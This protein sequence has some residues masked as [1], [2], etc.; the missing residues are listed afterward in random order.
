[1]KRQ[2]CKKSIL[3]LTLNTGTLR[4]LG[5]FLTHPPHPNT[6]TI[7]MFACVVGVHNAQYLALATS[8]DADG[9]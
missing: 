4:Q 6:V 8:L 3:I 2:V 1:M 7:Q 9:P 5:K